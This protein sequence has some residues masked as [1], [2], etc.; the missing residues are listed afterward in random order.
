MIEKTNGQVRIGFTVEAGDRDVRLVTRSPGTSIMGTMSNNHKPI[1]PLHPFAVDIDLLDRMLNFEITGDP[2]YSGLEIQGFDDPAHG[3]GMLVLLGRTDNGKTDVYFERGLQLDPASYAIGNGLGV[4]VETEFE[5]ARLDVHT[6][7]VEANVCF[8]DSEDRLIEVRAGDRTPRGRRT[9]AFLAPMGAAVAEPRSL[10]LIWMSKFDLLRRNGPS[11]IIRIDGRVVDIGRLPAEWLIRR[12]LIKVTSDL[13]AVAVNPAQEDPLPLTALATSGD[14]V[15]GVGGTRAIV[16]HKGDHEA[17]LTFDPP[18]PDLR[19]PSEV[20][21]GSGVWSA[22]I[23]GTPVVAGV[24][25][26]LPADGAARVD[27][28]VTDGWQPKGL[29]LLMSIVTRIAPVFRS[30]PTTYQWTATITDGK[31][32]T[33]TSQW[34]RTG[35]DRGESYR[36]FTRSG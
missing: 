10:P 4:W 3:R 31:T 8:F 7:G 21:S 32:P 34:T 11:P 14:T 36:S 20:R 6:E 27:L 1:A 9:A 24:W 29:P 2:H 12:R 17:R 15:G 33:M 35:S 23:D 22:A 25:R 26:V 5:T 19:K 30:W 16:G 13:C 18:F 28:E